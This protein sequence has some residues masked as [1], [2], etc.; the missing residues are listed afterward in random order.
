[1]F[2]DNCF[3]QAKAE[4]AKM[5]FD[6]SL[7]IDGEDIEYELRKAML[8]YT[9]ATG[10]YFL[11]S[12][13]DKLLYV[14]KSNNLLFR[15]ISHLYGNGG[16]TRTYS[17]SI[18]KMRIAIFPSETK[19]KRLFDIEKIF[20]SSMKPAFNGSNYADE[21]KQ[22]GYANKHNYISRSK[23]GNPMS[24]EEIKEILSDWPKVSGDTRN[25]G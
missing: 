1:M 18:K 13:D 21:L 25:A 15:L 14:G 10:I 2:D 12:S 5:I 4:C 6:Q 9:K 19:P 24:N 16:S 17:K 22:Y 23:N 3:E 7:I 11:I 8:P 20:I